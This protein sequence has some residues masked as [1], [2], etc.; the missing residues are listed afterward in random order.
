MLSFAKVSKLAPLA[1]LAYG[2]HLINQVSVAQCDESSKIAFSP[3][4][5]RSFTI[6]EVKQL[7]ANTKAIEIN[8]PTSE[9]EMGM[10]TASFLLVKGPL[11]P[12]G[13]PALRPYTPTSTNSKLM[14]LLI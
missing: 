7:S 4:E 6:K 12:D 10:K 5:F 11:G 3:K 9:H 2:F 1:S 14:Y 13:K 8:L